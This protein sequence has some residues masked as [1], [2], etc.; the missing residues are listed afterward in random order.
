[1]QNGP[2]GG[3]ID[4]KCEVDKEMD[5]VWY[6]IYE[7]LKKKGQLDKLKEIEKPKDWSKSTETRRKL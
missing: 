5:C 7:R 6:V 2:C 1:M 3:L 4:G